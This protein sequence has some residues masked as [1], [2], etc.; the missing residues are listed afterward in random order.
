MSPELFARYAS[1]LV[2][3][4]AVCTAAPKLNTAGKSIIKLRDRMLTI[5]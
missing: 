3:L 1:L 2:L 5:I 4:A